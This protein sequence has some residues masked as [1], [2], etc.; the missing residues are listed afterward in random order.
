MENR[1]YKVCRD[2]IFVGSVVRTDGIYFYGE[3][4]NNS[5]LSTGSWID[6]RSM[7]FVL[8][9]KRLSNDLLY[10]SPSYPILN[11]TDNETCLNLSRDIVVIKNA[12]NLA[13]LLEYFGYKKELTFDDIMRIRKTFF[14]G[15]FAQDNCELFGMK[16]VMA[17]DLTYYEGGKEVTN[18][19]R[20][21][22][23]MQYRFDQLA[24]HRMFGSISESQLPAEYWTILDSL[25]DNTLMDVLHGWDEKMN[26]F[27][28]RKEE[29]PIKKLT[30]F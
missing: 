2:D 28:P 21:L 24:G 23:M 12:C 30:R 27:V 15:K 1:C 22:R 13:P 4:K 16:E 7:L 19:K 26:A 18:L 25:G 17:K 9:E 14:T 5:K 20:I 6:Y 11:V 10:Q 8:D 29:G 3:S